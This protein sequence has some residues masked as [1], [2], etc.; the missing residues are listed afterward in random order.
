M[1]EYAIISIFSAFTSN[2]ADNIL[3]F[4]FPICECCCGIE[5]WKWSYSESSP[6]LQTGL[7]VPKAPSASL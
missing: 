3:I 4:F 7:H 2:A 6:V 1:D 5:S